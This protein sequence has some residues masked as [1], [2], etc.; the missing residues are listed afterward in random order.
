MKNLNH[1]N[2]VELSKEETILI[3][4]GVLPVVIAGAALVKGFGIGFGIVAAG[5][6]LY[7]AAKEAF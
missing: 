4:G 7:A 6:G 3:E 1:F 2:L 5:V